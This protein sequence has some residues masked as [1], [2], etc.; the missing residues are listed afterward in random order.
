MCSVTDCSISA[1]VARGDSYALAAQSDTSGD[2]SDLRLTTYT[3]NTSYR[4]E[5]VA[6]TA[7]GYLG[8]FQSDWVSDAQ[9]AS[10]WDTNSNTRPI[11]LYAERWDAA[12]YADYFEDAVSEAQT[13]RS[14]ALGIGIEEQAKVIADI[15]LYGGTYE[16]LIK[17]GV[18]FLPTYGRRSA[19]GAG[20]EGRKG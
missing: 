8:S 5:W 7:E 3:D 6:L 16:G 17:R 14:T 19:R 2:G 11:R 13:Q 18:G 10:Y 9:S 15:Q 4:D 12:Q 1:D 20:G